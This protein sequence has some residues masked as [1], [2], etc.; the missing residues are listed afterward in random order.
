MASAEWTVVSRSLFGMILASIPNSRNATISVED[1]TLEALFVPCSTNLPLTFSFAGGVDIAVPSSQ[2]VASASITKNAE[3][4]GPAAQEGECVAI[5][6]PAQ[7]SLTLP[8]EKSI[9]LGWSFLSSTYT[10]FKYGDQPQ[11]GFSPL[12]DAALGVEPQIVQGTN[13]TPTVS[14]PGYAVATGTNGSSN[15][16]SGPTS[17][18]SS[19]LGA[20]G[21]GAGAIALLAA[22][23]MYAV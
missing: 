3:G 21:L 8:D 22:V 10:V 13:A 23:A 7:G 4:F 19:N 20:A 2:W 16:T 17:G 14:I 18:A 1:N 6:L 11:M 12:T 15:S 5:I 9:F